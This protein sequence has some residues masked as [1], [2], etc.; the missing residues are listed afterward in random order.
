LRATAA[1]QLASEQLNTAAC[2]RADERSEEG[3]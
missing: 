3:W 2:S 1:E